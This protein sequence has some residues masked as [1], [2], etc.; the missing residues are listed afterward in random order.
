MNKNFNNIS[1]ARYFDYRI[2]T[3]KTLPISTLKLDYD[4]KIGIHLST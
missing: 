4:L 1:N 3:R 2:D